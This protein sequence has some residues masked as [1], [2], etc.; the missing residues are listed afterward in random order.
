[1]HIKPILPKRTFRVQMEQPGD[2]II[3]PIDD[4]G[5]VDP[6]QPFTISD[7]NGMY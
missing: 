7:R 2:P 1:L 6:V 5:V 4:V 3:V